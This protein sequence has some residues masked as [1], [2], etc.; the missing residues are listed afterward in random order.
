MLS[1]SSISSNYMTY[2][3]INSRHMEEVVADLATRIKKIDEELRKSILNYGFTQ[4][5]PWR[6]SIQLNIFFS[7]F[8]HHLFYF[9][10]SELS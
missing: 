4:M 10:L 6:R 5:R 7:I 2:V 3:C 8:S 1:Y 9:L